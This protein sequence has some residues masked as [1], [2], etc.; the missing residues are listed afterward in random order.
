MSVVWPTRLV[1]R[2]ASGGQGFDSTSRVSRASTAVSVVQLTKGDEIYMVVGQEGTSACN[3]HSQVS[4]RR[5]DESVD[6]PC[7]RN[8]LQPV[9]LSLSPQP[10][11]SRRQGHTRRGREIVSLTG[12]TRRGRDCLT[13]GVH[14][15]RPRLSH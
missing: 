6:L 8:H 2:G 11:L 13:D 3:K 4:G 1:A 14:Q 9:P 12:S 7:V 15:T 10:S 5:T